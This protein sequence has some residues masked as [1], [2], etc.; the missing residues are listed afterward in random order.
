[1]GQLHQ[2]PAE[3]RRGRH[4]AIRD[5]LVGIRILCF[6]AGW[7]GVRGYADGE[8]VGLPVRQLAGRP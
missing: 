1:M 6:A 7:V 2:C 3:G 5:G 4:F 8:L